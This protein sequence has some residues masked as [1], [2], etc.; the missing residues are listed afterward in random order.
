MSG[1]LQRA[2]RVFEIPVGSTA[3]VFVARLKSGGS[4]IDLSAA[5][6]AKLFNAKTVDG[7]AIVTGGVASFY[8][9]GSDGK[10]QFPLTLLATAVRDVYIDVEVQGLSGNTLVSYTFILRFTPRAI[11]S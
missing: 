2:L 4:A 9:D 1:E 5:S 10:V 8:T 3:S 6:G 11:G 7:A